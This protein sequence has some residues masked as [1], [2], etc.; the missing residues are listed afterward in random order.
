[1]LQKHAVPPTIKGKRGGKRAGLQ[2]CV[3]TRG[4][5]RDVGVQFKLSHC[6]AR[7]PS[8]AFPARRPQQS[9]L[10]CGAESSFGGN[11]VVGSGKH[12][13]LQF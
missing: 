9:W 7:E 11:T 10:T 4:P 12:L 1:M 6:V 5:A 8:A 13:K 3:R 2:Q